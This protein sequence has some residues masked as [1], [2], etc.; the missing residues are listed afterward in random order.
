MSSPVGLRR[1]EPVSDT[2]IL[3]ALDRAERHA[4]PNPWRETGVYWR[5]L[6]EHLGFLHAPWT[7]RKLRPQ[8]EALIDAGLV[9]RTK[10]KGRVRW[11]LTD[12]GAM[13]VAQARI[14][15]EAVLPDSPRRREWQEKRSEAK[16]QIESIRERLTT[17]GW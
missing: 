15:G 6:V 10:N 7:T 14:D 2:L 11:G 5:P 12:A 8:L 13:R 9:T 1:F 16:E 17:A 4:R 3:V